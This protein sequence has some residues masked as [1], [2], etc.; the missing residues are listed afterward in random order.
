ADPEKGFIIGRGSSG[1]NLG[2]GLARLAVE[3]A[4]KPA[5]TGHWVAFPVSQR[6]ST[7]PEK[8]KD[9][10]T[11]WTQNADAMLVDAAAGEALLDIYGLVFTSPL[12]NPLVPGFDVGNLPPAYVQAAGMDLIRDDEIVYSYVLDDAKVAVGLDAYAGVPHSF[13]TFV[14]TLKQSR[15]AMVD[16]AKGFA[17]LLNREV[18]QEKAEAAILLNYEILFYV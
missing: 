9:I 11:S 5:L 2:P 14:S 4:L 10:W 17:W 1:G 18:D 7:V 8:Y 13:Y 16:I 12:F 15:S 6:N 3:K